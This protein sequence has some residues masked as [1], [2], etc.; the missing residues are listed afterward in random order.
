[1]QIRKFV[2]QTDYQQLRQC[3]IDL[4]DFERK[5]DPRMPEGELI[6]DDYMVNMF[7]ECEKYSGLI[8]VAEKDQRIHGYITVLTRYV[9]NDIDDGPR[10]YG[11]ITDLF[12]SEICRGQG[13]GKALLEHVELQLLK[14]NINELKI[15]VLASNKVARSLYQAAGFKAFAITLEKKIGE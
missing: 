14:K 9:S 13:I 12:V 2:K 4:Q 15:G 5:L 6:S 1:M 7:D 3:T 11:Y 8:F 10:E